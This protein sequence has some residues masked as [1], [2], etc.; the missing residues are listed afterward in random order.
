[1]VEFRNPMLKMD[2]Y[3]I[4]TTLLNVE[5]FYLVQLFINITPDCS[6]WEILIHVGYQSSTTLS[7]LE[8]L[9]FMQVFIRL[10]QHC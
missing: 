9:L 10:A 3:Q 7:K 1:M 6:T 8:K 2:V 5:N 4:G